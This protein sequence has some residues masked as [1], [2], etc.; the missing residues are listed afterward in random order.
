MRAGPLGSQRLHPTHLPCSVGLNPTGWQHALQ[1]GSDKA[2]SHPAASP[3]AKGPRVFLQI[4]T[5]GPLHLKTRSLKLFMS[6][7]EVM[8]GQVC[9]SPNRCLGTKKKFG[10]EG[11]RG[12][13]PRMLETGWHSLSGKQGTC[14]LSCNHTWLEEA[15]RG[16]L[17]EAWEDA[18]P[19][20]AWIS[21]AWP[22]E[23]W[24]EAG[25]VQ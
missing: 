21:D 3:A 7:D 14:R 11:T 22:P 9:P 15:R 13:K 20:Y 25:I 18:G 4:H 23:L 19:G 5:P 1:T 17:L 12:R 16:S 2:A 8:V 24:E 6:S 10:L